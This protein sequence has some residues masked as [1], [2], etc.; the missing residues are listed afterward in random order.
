MKFTSWLLRLT[1][2]DMAEVWKCLPQHSQPTQMENNE[3]L[4]IERKYST[5]ANYRGGGGANEAAHCFGRR[6]HYCSS[7]G[8]YTQHLP[9]KARWPSNVTHFHGN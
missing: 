9:D 2:T 4:L 1:K 7:S 5:R 6:H 3:P 8:G